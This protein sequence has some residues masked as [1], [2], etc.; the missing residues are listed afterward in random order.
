M[1]LAL[2]F[3]PKKIM[4]FTNLEKKQ[5]RKRADNENKIE[6]EKRANWCVG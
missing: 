1:F 2:M 6:G 3:R 5:T 4:I